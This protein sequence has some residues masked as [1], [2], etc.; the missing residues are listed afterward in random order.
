MPRSA[1]RF[2]G[3]KPGLHSQYG[4]PSKFIN[5]GSSTAGKILE[6]HKQPSSPISAG[7]NIEETELKTESSH[8]IPVHCFLRCSSG[9]SS[10]GRYLSAVGESYAKKKTFSFCNQYAYFNEF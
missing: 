10:E 2:A 4:L 8:L 6:I 9:H 7:G 1:T 3:F 5:L